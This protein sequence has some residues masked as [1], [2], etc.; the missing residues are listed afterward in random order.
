MIG[1]PMILIAIG[2][3]MLQGISIVPPVLIALGI[4]VFLSVAF[5]KNPETARLFNCWACCN[6]FYR[7][8]SN[9]EVHDQAAR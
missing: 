8:R 7:E 6:P 5:R 2:V 1:S 9:C 4:A 3:A